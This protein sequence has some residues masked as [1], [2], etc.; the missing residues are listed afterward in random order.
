M[1]IATPLVD[2]GNNAATSTAMRS[3]LRIRATGSC[4]AESISENIEPIEFILPPSRSAAVIAV[5]PAGPQRVPLPGRQHHAAGNADAE[6]VHP[7][8]VEIEDVRVEQRGEDVL[9]DDQQSDPGDEPFATKQQQ[10]H[11]PH[12]VQQ[13]DPDDT[14]LHRNVQCLVVWIGDYLIRGLL[15]WSRPARTARASSPFRGR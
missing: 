12:R 2:H 11:Q 1:P 8:L 7:S 10:V 9:Y 4:R 14:P 13:D 3:T 5:S 6:H 15:V